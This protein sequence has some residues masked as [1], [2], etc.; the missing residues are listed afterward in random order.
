MF[1]VLLTCFFYSPL[2]VQHIMDVE[3]TENYPVI[4]VTLS[5]LSTKSPADP[6][7][8]FFS[9]DYGMM[10]IICSVYL[11]LPVQMFSSIKLYVGRHTLRSQIIS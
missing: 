11:N 1:S 5:S 10:M 4:D 3:M 2:L 9:M 8:I 7:M 6:T